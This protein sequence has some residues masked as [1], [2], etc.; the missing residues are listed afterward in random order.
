MSHEHHALDPEL[1]GIEDAL[2]SIAPA[3]SRLDRDR[4]M[5]RAGQAA[6]RPSPF[7]QRLW[8]AIAASTGLVA[9]GEAAL[10]ARRPHPQVVERV[11]VVR[12]PAPT[13]LV[14]HDD[15]T[16][17]QS[18]P[19]QRLPASER[20]SSLG[21]TASERLASQVLRYGL[22][23]LPTPPSYAGSGPALW[24]VP[25]HQLLQEELQEF[26]EPGGPS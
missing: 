18:P 20:P 23:G 8:V 10:L 16:T 6:N 7:G 5:F 24:P 19:S 9:L 3:P 12:E 1:S 14:R 4:L 2:G 21:S 15:R 17:A 26:L 25:A 11:V 22:D 13:P